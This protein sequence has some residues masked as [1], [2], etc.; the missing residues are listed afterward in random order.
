METPK[1]ETPKITIYMTD[2]CGYCHSTKR[3]LESKGIAYQTINVDENEEAAE[4]VTRINGGYRIVPTI[5]IEGKGVFTN[6][7]R[8]EL[9]KL[10]DLA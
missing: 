7:S 8:Q 5:D 2:W 3:F 10:L 6:P 4:L 9:S 1:V